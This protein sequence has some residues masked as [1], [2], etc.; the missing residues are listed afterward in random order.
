MIIKYKVEILERDETA[1]YQ[2][3]DQ[4][5]CEPPSV[6]VL[7][8]RPVRRLIGFEDGCGGNA[9]PFDKPLP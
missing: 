9:S 7:R 5:V 8:R 2:N 1:R 3:L 6:G 4:P